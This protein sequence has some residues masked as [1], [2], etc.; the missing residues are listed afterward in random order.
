MGQICIL[1]PCNSLIS[2]FLI[3]LEIP[4]YHLIKVRI[5]RRVSPLPGELVLACSVNIRL[6]GSGEIV[7]NVEIVPAGSSKIIPAG[8]S[9]II[10]AGSSEIIPAG[11]SKIIPAGSSEIIP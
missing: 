1:V 7:G 2:W 8:S 5:A 4:G 10:P 6:A 9:E 3:I 11:S